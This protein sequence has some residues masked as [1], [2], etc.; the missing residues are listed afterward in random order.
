MKAN[1]SKLTNADLGSAND[2]NNPRVTDVE[3]H[4]I[5]D[6][7]KGKGEKQELFLQSNAISIR[8]LSPSLTSSIDQ[9]RSNL[10]NF[11]VSSVNNITTLIDNANKYTPIMY[12]K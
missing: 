2:G 8:N 12:V 11:S 7:W 1:D 4:A 9:A 10:K 6:D 3:L 5:V